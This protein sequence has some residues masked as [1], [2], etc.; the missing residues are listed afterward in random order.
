MQ[1]RLHEMRREMSDMGIIDETSRGEG[2]DEA[3][4]I[5]GVVGVV[6]AVALG[7]FKFFNK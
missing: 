1:R 6:G 3:L 5:G 2:I 4:K 7:L